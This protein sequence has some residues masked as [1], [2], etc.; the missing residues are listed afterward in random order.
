ME[1]N[2]NQRGK[3]SSLN[4]SVILSF[5]VAAFSIVAF[6]FIGIS[7]LQNSGVSYAADVADQF[8]TSF[9]FNLLNGG[10][11]VAVTSSNRTNPYSVPLYVADND[12]KNP[13][14]CIEHKAD[15]SDDIVYTAGDGESDDDYG[16]LYLLNNSYANGVSKIDANNSAIQGATTEAKAANA[17]YVNAW[18][19][20]TA[21]WM[22][23]NDTA[24][25]VPDGAISVHTIE[26]EDIADIKGA[27]KLTLVNQ[28]AGRSE[29]IYSGANLY[30]TYVKGLVDAAK[31]ATNVAVLNVSKASDEVA[32]SPDKKFYDSALITVTG[33]PSS[34]LKNFEIKLNGIEG[35]KAIDED[36]KELTTNVLPGTKFYVRIPAEKVTKEVQKVVV[37]INA[38]FTTLIGK[39]YTGVVR[40]TLGNETS[41]QEVVMVKA[42]ERNVS[43]GTEVEFVGT[44]DTGMNTVQTIYFIGLIVL[45]CGVGIVYANAKPVQVK[46]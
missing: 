1:D 42:G 10:D 36:G 23:L 21:I 6:A 7:S 25:P 29:L 20:Q 9:T 33:D 22:Y 2:N 24:G 44:E 28:D 30:D 40:D 35:A 19:T 41:L 45:L 43:D 15:V 16:L 37:T 31:K 5:A 34:S 3:Q 11:K 32:Q 38:N 18:I 14:F 27:T 8:P 13:L 39:T 46:Q 17:K 12:E 26:N 4:G